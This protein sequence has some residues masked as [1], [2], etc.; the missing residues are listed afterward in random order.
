L[1]SYEWKITFSWVKA[2]VGIYCN[3]LADILAKEVA[4][5][6]RT[7]IAFNR[8]PKSTLY[9][10]EAA[11]EAKQQWQ[12][13]WRTCTK[14]AKKK[15]YFPTIQDRL[16]IKINLSPNLPAMLTRHGRTRAYLHHFKLWDDA[17]RICG[18]G[19]QTTDHLLNHCT[20]IHTQREVLKQCI[21]KNGNWP[22]SKQE[23]IT[24]YRD[25]F[26]TFI[27]SIDSELL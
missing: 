26:I 15:K 1:E 23:L 14:A 6:N 7:S 9:Y 16:R 24:N 17:K 2:L 13:E 11:E 27:E 4:Q 5:S 22:T 18:Q 12:D 25:S 19:D 20:M 3:E 10:Y 21:F 8:I